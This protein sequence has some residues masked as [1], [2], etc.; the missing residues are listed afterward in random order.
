MPDGS[1][2]AGGDT[3]PA[4]SPAQVEG[5]PIVG[6]SEL[7]FSAS[8]TES[9]EP[10]VPGAGP[11]GLLNFF[12]SHAGGAE[13]GISGVT[14]PT[15]SL[16]GVFLGPDQPSDSPCPPVSTSVRPETCLEE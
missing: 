16:L 10:S 2:A 3:A 15:D 12:V 7:S 13:N 1:T 11:D 9:Y 14:A 6:G 4:E 8:G 5:I